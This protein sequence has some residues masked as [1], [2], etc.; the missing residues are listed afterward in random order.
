MR[1]PTTRQPHHR[2]YG[3]ENEGSEATVRIASWHDAHEVTCALA[4]KSLAHLHV[5]WPNIEADIERCCKQCK[6]C[7]E[8]APNQPQ[9]LSTWLVPDK[10]H[11]A[12]RDGCSLEM[13]TRH[14]T[15]QVPDC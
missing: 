3:A 4:M 5:W 10:R 6:P 8:T 15:E 14:Q 12:C 13:A 1:C 9:N 2:T 11:V 7:A